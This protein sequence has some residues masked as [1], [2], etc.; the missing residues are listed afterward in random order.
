[1]RATHPVRV[2]PSLVGVS[3]GAG[4]RSEIMSTS[5]YATA[6]RGT[7]AGV[8]RVVWISNHGDDGPLGGISSERA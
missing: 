4:S 1:M 3:P 2:V 5:T 8:P 6:R 7:P